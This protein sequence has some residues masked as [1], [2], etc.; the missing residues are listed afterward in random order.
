MTITANNDSFEEPPG[1]MLVVEQGIG[2][3][4]VIPLD[5][6]IL[7]LGKAGSADVVLDNPYV[8]RQHAEIRREREGYLIRD[9]AS[10]NGTF[11]NGNRLNTDG[12][13][14]RTSDRIE[15][16]PGEVV[17]RFQDWNTTT[18][19]PVIGT[20]LPEDLIVDSRSRDVIIQGNKV[21]PPLSRKEFDILGLLYER[22]QEACS[23]DQIAARGWPDREGGDV[24]D[25]EIEQCIRRLR[26]RI[27]TDPSQPR[28]ILTVR[29]FG[30]KLN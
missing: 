25:Q 19:L 14:L 1:A 21:Q 29:G 10:K 24:G 27:E 23:K 22:R 12:H 17:L 18:T 15:L 13:W 30:Y 7:M 5:Q 20:P 4:S 8:S 9:L 11:I 26:L 3:M 28:H 16:A 6:P 2:E